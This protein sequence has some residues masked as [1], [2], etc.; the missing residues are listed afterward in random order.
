MKKASLLLVS[1][2]LLITSG[3]F[4][5]LTGVKTIGGASPDYTTIS[6]AITALSSSGVGSGGVTFRIRQGTY[7]GQYALGTVSGASASNPVRFAPDASNT[8]PVVLTYSGTSSSSMG[9]FKFT[10]GA[11]YIT[12]DSLILRNMG[13]SYSSAVEMSGSNSYITINACRMTNPNNS[14]TSSSYNTAVYDN[15]G[16]TDQ[17]NNVSITH[18]TIDSVAF[19]TYIYGSSSSSQQIGWTVS[20]NHITAHYAGLWIYYSNVSCNNNYVRNSGNYSY[21]YGIRAYYT[22]NSEFIGND[23][24]LGNG[25]YGYGLYLYYPYA[26]STARKYV[27]NNT[28]SIVGMSSGTNYGLYARYA[29]YCDIVHNSVNITSGSGYGLYFYYGS[30]VN[31]HNNSVVNAGSNYTLYRTG[32]VSSTGQTLSNNNFYGP[33]GA[34]ANGISGT[35]NTAVDPAYT[36]NYDL[37]AASPVLH[38]AGLAITGIMNDIDNQVRCPG[39]GCPGSASAPD[40]G[41]DEYYLPPN[42]ATPSAFGALS[43]CTGSNNIQ[44]KVRN[45]GTATL[46]SVNVAWA[47]KTNTGSFVAQTPV[48]ITGMSIAS[49]ADTTITLGSMTVAAGNTYQLQA[50]TSSPSGVTDQNT[51]NDTLLSTTFSSAM[52]GTYSVGGTSPDFATPVAA[53]AALDANGM[54]GAIT[55]N[56][57]QGTYTGQ[58]NIGAITG[59]SSVNTLTI[60]PDPANTATVVLTAAGTSS[61]NMGVFNLN[62]AKYVNIKKLTIRNTGTSYARGIEMNGA[63]VKIAV[64]SCTFSNPNHTSTTS[65][66]NCG[67]YDYSGS[68]Q[69][70]SISITHCTI[71]SVAYG[72]YVYGSSSSVQQTGWTVS[73]NSI[74]AHYYGLYLYYT[75][76]SCNNNYVRNSGNYSYPYG[77]YTYYTYNSEFIGNDIEL[78]NGVYGYGLYLNYP[79]ATSTARKYVANNTISIVGMSSG[80]NYGLYAYYANYCD[81]VHNSV[82]ITS[83]SGYGIYF[84][85]G[86]YVNLHNNSVVNAG[87]N[88]TLY[89]TGTVS[90]T[91]QTLSHNNFYGPNG[92]P[93]YGISGTGNT[94]VDPAYT[95]NYDLHAA[96][97]VM[98]NAGLAIT[99]IMNDIDNEVRCPGSGCPGS[100]SAPDI[101]ADEYELP[102][103][104]ASAKAFG[105]LSFC[106]GTGAV[107]ITIRNAG[108]S[109]LTSVNVAWA[110]KTNTGSFVAQTPVVLTGIGIASG[111][112]STINLGNITVAMGNSYQLQAYTYTP[113]GVTDQNT[114]NDTL[115]SAV[116]APA[117]SG[118]YT[119]GGSSP[120]FADLATALSYV[121]ANGLCGAVTLNIR[122]GTYTAQ[123]NLGAIPGVS[124]VNTLTIQADPANTAEVLLQYAGTSSSNMGVFNLNNATYVNIKKLTIRNTGTSYARGIEMNGANVKIAVDSCTFSN[125]N[126]TSTSS[127]YNCGIYDNS[128]SNQSDSISITHCT[129][130][131][132]AYGMYIYGSSSS[133]QQTGWTVSNNSITAHYYGLYLYYTNV[134]CNNNYLRNSGNYSYPYGIRAYY[135]YNSE[136]IG[137]D[138]ELGNGVYGNG[139]YLYRPYATS[140]ARKYV[141]NNTISLVGMSSGSNYGLYAYY[142]NYCDIVHNSVNITSGSGYGLYF[143]YGSYV[144]LHNNSVVNA[145]SNYTLYRTGTVSSTGQ[146]LSN[147]NFY[148][149]NGATAYGLSGTGNISANPRFYNNYDLHASDTSHNNAGLN[150]SGIMNDID[151]EVRC[152]GSG[153]PGT[154]TAPDIGADE[155][156]PPPCPFPS[157]VTATTVA[158]DSLQVSWTTGGASAWN[159]EYGVSGFTQGAGTMLK[160]VTTN[161][162][163]I[164]G[165]TLGETYDIYVQDSCGGGNGSSMWIKVTAKLWYCA[166]NV[167]YIGDTKIDS[168]FMGCGEVFGSSP[169]TPETYTFHPQ[170]IKIVKGH[171]MPIRL[172]NGSASGSHYSAYAK[173]WADVNGDLNFSEPSERFLVYGPTT[174]LNHTNIT[175]HVVIPTTAYTGKVGMRITLQESGWPGACNNLIYGEVEDFILN[176]VDTGDVDAGL[177]AITD[178]VCASRDSLYVTLVNKGKNTLTAATINW[179]LQDTGSMVMQSPYSWTGSLTTGQTAVINLG[180]VNLNTSFTNIFRAF[181]SNPNSS[182][183]EN[184]GNDTMSVT[185]VVNTN[186]MVT[187]STDSSCSNVSPLALTTGTPAGGVYSGTNVSSGNFDV[188]TAGVGTHGVTYKYTD[189]NSC[190]TSVAA[191]IVVTSAPSITSVSK[192]NLSA[193]GMTDGAISISA[194][195]GTGSLQYGIGGASGTFQSTGSFTSLGVGS[196]TPFVKDGLGCSESG[197]V[198]TISAPSTPAAP[199]VVN[200]D[201]YCLKDVILKL[202]AVKQ[203]GATVKWYSNV[204]L[205]TLLSTG[206]S[207]APDTSTGLHTY[208]ASQTIAGCESPGTQVDVLVHPLPVVS[209]GSYSAVCDNAASFSLS[210]GS[211]SGGAYSGTGVSSGSFDP[212]TAGAGTASITYTYTDG[213]GCTDNANSS[214]LVNAKTAASLSS[215]SALCANA[216]SITL[217]NG[218]PTGGVYSGTGVSS[219][220]F[221]PSSAGVGT[222]TIKYVYTDGNSCMD[223]TTTTQQVD[224]VTTVTVAGLNNICHNASSLTLSNGTPAGG[225]YSGTGVSSGSFDP[226]T[227]GVGTHTI[228]YVYTNAFSCMDSSSTSITVDSVTTVSMSSLANLCANAGTISLTNA[229]PA[230]GVYSGTGV[231]GGNFN[232]VTAGAGVHT[233]KYVFTNGYS[234][235]DSTTTSITVD[236]VTMASMT[237]LSNVCVNTPAFTLSN[238]SP[239]G[240]VYSGA[241][242]SSGSFDPSVSGVGTHI[243]QY[244]YTNAYSCMD[245]TSVNQTVD[246]LTPMSF[247]LPLN[248]CLNSP[249]I[250]LNGQ[251]VGGVYTGPNITAGVYSAI[252]LGHDTL[253]YAYTNGLMCMDSLTAVIRVDSVPVVSFGAISDVCVGSG[254]FALSQGM[255]TGGTYSGIGVSSGSY[256]PSAV[257]TDTIKYTFRD[258]NTCTDSAFSTVTVHAL[259]VV[260]LSGLSA[261]CANAPVFGLSGGTP[262]GGTYKGTGVSGSNYDPGM[263]MI[264]NNLITYV[265]TDGNSCTDS[266]STQL[267]VNDKPVVTFNPLTAV[268]DN[269]GIVSLSGGLPVGGTYSGSHVT[270]GNFDPAGGGAGTYN[271]TYTYTDGNSCTDSVT[272]VQQVQPS[273]IFTLSGITSGC[274]KSYPMLWTSAPS[275]HVFHWSNG[276]R[277]DTCVATNSGSIWVKVTDPTTLQRCYNRDTISVSY[278]ATCLGLGDIVDNAEMR[279]YP[280]PTSGA[281]HVEIDGLGGEEVTLYLLDVNGR[282]VRQQYL[283][284]MPAAYVTTISVEE[285]PAGIY[286]LNIVARD[287][288]KT[289]MLT[290]TR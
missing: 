240:G 19:G 54:C 64:D 170:V 261:V 134:S 76:V 206:D 277:G 246:S 48:S 167:S 115:T 244:R 13:Y 164:G 142:A 25:V 32:T 218:T 171:S 119:V 190:W 113:N 137:N 185:L 224:S 30:Y 204:T 201:T 228:K 112:D 202:G 227:A 34:T 284:Q 151:D 74:T 127:N 233:I 22:Y 222:H 12:I 86:S 236:S 44:L 120:S 186:P 138:I 133:V 281:V 116:F 216:S 252:A 69:S 79:Y 62:N 265:Y 174:M 80:A 208:Y 173:V 249:D 118:T 223:S 51:S 148:G 49:G 117:L 214:I 215:L 50:S 287:V 156:V 1:G 180:T 114:S 111:T 259:P 254:V 101:G 189:S 282:K 99:G 209:L 150:I 256:N 251:P 2:L 194:T 268:C 125:P 166:S 92:A 4:A 220:S 207:L 286:Y 27:A 273:P 68:N 78:S 83:G 213:N 55:L 96:S 274:G 288:V 276:A 128:G 40:I 263:G 199:S 3:L 230:G 59:A 81:I 198:Q 53:I 154:G 270:G 238:G 290:I 66:Y 162:L 61:S 124:S 122:Q 38:N 183:D 11:S 123:Y 130:D 211:P 143:S 5:Q 72:M 136:F 104:D 36:S 212:A 279:Y 56:I 191:N 126:H 42:D 132:V 24:E 45:A 140:T 178:T 229:S 177:M 245:S 105:S 181:T 157:G 98:H 108:L 219:G 43:F 153:C 172:V 149:P 91:G 95:S 152:P 93:A 88:Y 70:D 109:T 187:M 41:A 60:Q 131:S 241:G 147:N 269:E 106:P 258:A 285:L 107:Q 168:V 8:A 260:Q 176:I 188:T 15:S 63:N 87:S 278:E 37:H 283:G 196:Y 67:I 248:N 46:T 235:M 75:N 26:T 89:R 275:T 193:C 14:G 58:L 85:Y 184:S 155:F 197:T 257:T 57:R 264:G 100:A 145:G 179:G 239:T 210:G 203:T 16:S 17:S 77:I 271:I 237:S 243:V 226:T 141:A 234:C 102:A 23:I 205:T 29:N 192:S 52:S 71:D 144:N 35:G 175:S 221:D 6:A 158:I 97:P 232:P 231:S 195:G 146:T 82:N 65:T 135:T 242:V 200:A 266:A 255:P 73:N 280:N 84:Y 160:N 10:G 253:Q 28:I 94:A 18:C 90:S 250:T 272:V 121:N 33:N 20:N 217:S 262:S 163:K 21:P 169:S 267:M 247:T 7:T 47:L 139:L 159:I 129:I 31:L 39:S 225:V 165:L 182:C 161:P 110:L 103:N 9:I 289:G